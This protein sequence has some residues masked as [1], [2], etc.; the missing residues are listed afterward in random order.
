MKIWLNLGTRTV[1]TSTYC[2]SELNRA[3]CLWTTDAP[4][5]KAF[6]KLFGPGSREISRVLTAGQC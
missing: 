2:K 5:Y 6:N 3:Y 4:L 1:E